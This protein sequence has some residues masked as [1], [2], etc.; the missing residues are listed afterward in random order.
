L[1]GEAWRMVLAISPPYMLMSRLM[2][3][4]TIIYWP[5]R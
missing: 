1:G 2:K 4:A 3:T 5:A